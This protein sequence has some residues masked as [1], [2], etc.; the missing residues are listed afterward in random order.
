LV[1][2][3]PTPST[4]PW[5]VG[6]VKKVTVAGL[7]DQASS[8]HVSLRQVA[9]QRV[10]T[11]LQT[12]SP[13]PAFG[14]D[15]SEHLVRRLSR[16]RLCLMEMMEM[17]EWDAGDAVTSFVPSQSSGGPGR[18]GPSGAPD[19]KPGITSDTQPDQPPE[20]GGIFTVKTDLPSRPSTMLP[21]CHRAQQQSRVR[22]Q[23]MNRG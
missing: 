1:K 3:R 12:P 2:P 11:Y 9:I 15:F 22:R 10:R 4:R 13:S 17:D 14:W 16:V 21:D 19:L 8:R 5:A 7:L 20:Y 23:M 6:T 18:G